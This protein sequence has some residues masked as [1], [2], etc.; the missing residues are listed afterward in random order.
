MTRNNTLIIC[1]A[2]I[3]L[4]AIGAVTY[5]ANTQT[6]D[7]AAL[8]IISVIVTGVLAGT[9]G[10]GKLDRIEQ[11]VEQVSRQTNGDLHSTIEHIVEQRLAAT[12][13]KPLH[14]QSLSDR[15]DA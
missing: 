8:G 3:L 14:G 2:L 7:L 12:G 9:F 11:R 4:A 1:G 15:D 13:Q 10:L 6:P 5:L